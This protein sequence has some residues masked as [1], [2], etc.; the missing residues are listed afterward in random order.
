MVVIDKSETD[1]G[2]ALYSRAQSYQDPVIT[3]QDAIDKGFKLKVYR[4]I[5]KAKPFNDTGTVWATTSKEVAQAYAEEVF[6]YDDAAVITM[7][8]NTDG[9]RKT[10]MRTASDEVLDSFEYNTFTSPQDVGIYQNSDDSP[11]GNAYPHTA[12]HVPIENTVVIDNGDALFSRSVDNANT[13]VSEYEATRGINQLQAA[14][15]KTSETTKSL[16]P[17]RCLSISLREQEEHEALEKQGLLNSLRPSLPTLGKKVVTFE[18]HTPKIF[19]FNG[20]SFDG[21]IFLNAK[22]NRPAHV[23]FGHE[24]LHE[25]KK[26]NQPAYDKLMDVLEPM[27]KNVEGFRNA[28]NIEASRS[29]DYVKEELAANLVGNR[30][31]EKSFWRMLM[32]RAPKHFKAIVELAVKLLSEIHLNITGNAKLAGDEFITDMDKA[33]EAIADAVASYRKMT[34]KTFEPK[35]MTAWH[36][37]RMTMTSLIRVRLVQAKGRRLTGMDCTLLGIRMLQSITRHTKHRQRLGARILKDGPN[38]LFCLGDKE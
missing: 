30:F 11:L 1:K 14:V 26:G 17:S 25:L 16:Y 6:G 32:L 3:E 9:I 27:M 13:E 8:V 35:Y 29:V 19:D 23:I 28:E 18:N 12:V 33:R 38:G 37:S 21:K 24:F 10:D 2:T 20:V 7:M 5:S 15:R 22:A 34:G 36:G 31:A 4:G